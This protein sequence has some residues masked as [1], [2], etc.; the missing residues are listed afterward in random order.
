MDGL[1]LSG[2]GS[3]LQKSLSFYPEIRTRH[4]EQKSA[5]FIRTSAKAFPK[6][7]PV[8]IRIEIRH[9]GG[10]S[11]VLR[12]RVATTIIMLRASSLQA[13]DKAELGF[14]DSIAATGIGFAGKYC[15]ELEW[16]IFEE[17]RCDRIQFEC[18]F[19]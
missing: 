15:S 10:L 2:R 16:E 13:I 6:I 4:V 8:F 5:V 14:Q 12:R 3:D 17:A 19:L 1:I 11:G 9:F 18:N 7:S